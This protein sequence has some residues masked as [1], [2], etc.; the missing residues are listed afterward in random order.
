MKTT[1]ALLAVLLTGCMSL[2]SEQ[3]LAPQT[4]EALKNAPT[5]SSKESCDALMEMAQVWVT[6]N[7]RMRIQSATSAIISTYDDLNTI[8]E[9]PSFYITKEP[10]GAGTYKLILAAANGF[11][12]GKIITKWE[13]ELNWRLKFNADLKAMSK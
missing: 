7:T 12:D 6:K 3:E 8:Q 13:R 9:E 11:K 1:I 5:C 4:A 10:A 2:K